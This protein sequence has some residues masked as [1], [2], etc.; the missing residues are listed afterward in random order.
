VFRIVRLVRPTFRVAFEYDGTES[1]WSKDG[2][3]TKSPRRR[4]QKRTFLSEVAAYRW[5]ARRMIF[6]RRDRLCIGPVPEDEPGAL[7][8][9]VWCKPRGFDDSGKYHGLCKYHDDDSFRRLEARL[10]SW[11]RWRDSVSAPR[12]DP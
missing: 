11:L 7:P 5:L 4:V 2:D 12:K 1:Q 6:A 10:S 3:E 9:C 8:S